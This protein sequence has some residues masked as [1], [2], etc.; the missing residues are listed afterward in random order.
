M[1]KQ[2]IELLDFL[3]EHEC[4]D[5]YQAYEKF[6]SDVPEEDKTKSID[7]SFLSDIKDGR[8]KHFSDRSFEHIRLFN[9]EEKADDEIA[10]SIS[11]RLYICPSVEN[12]QN[13]TKRIVDSHLLQGTD[14]ICKIAKNMGRNDRIVIYLTGNFDEEVDLIRE[15]QND[16]PELFAECRKNKLWCDIDG[17]ENVYYGEE[18][19]NKAS[20]YGEDRARIIGEIFALQ[21]ENIIDSNNE[22]DLKNAYRLEC[23]KRHINPFNWGFYINDDKVSSAADD[24]LY[25]LSDVEFQQETEYKDSC[26]IV[27]DWIVN[28]DKNSNS[29]L[30]D[31]IPEYKGL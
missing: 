22:E 12:M 23:L 30:G 24:V 7:T 28:N 6:I 9:G 31:N 18:P 14:L 27:D 15:I 29:W 5:E 19:Q 26:K 11:G 10:S 16:S 8:L 2:I 17:L 1:P 25:G 20:S 13:L 3:K 4:K 21:K